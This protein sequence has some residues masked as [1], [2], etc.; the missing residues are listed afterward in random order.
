VGHA[1]FV[2]NR[3]RNDGE[4]YGAVLETSKNPRDSDEPRPEYPGLRN[5]ANYANQ[6]A[7]LKAPALRKN[8]RAQAYFQAE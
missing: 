5:H 4:V 2:E 8:L 3:A 6:D 1:L 7:G